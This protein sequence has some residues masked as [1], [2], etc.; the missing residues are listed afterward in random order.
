MINYTVI[1]HHDILH[2][3]SRIPKNIRN[4]LQRAI[5]TRL[6]IDP[7]GYGLPLR[8]NLH[9]HRK[10]RVGDYRIIYRIDGKMI[11]VVKIGHRKDVYLKLLSRIDS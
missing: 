2:D 4:T 10:L 8:K 9:G 3:L 11:I 6:L 1:Y 7:I 5:E